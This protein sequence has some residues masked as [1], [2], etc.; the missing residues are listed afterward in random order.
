[1]ITDNNI[2]L[3]RLSIHFTHLTQSLDVEVFQFFKQTHER[4]IDRVVKN[5]D[6][7]F[8]RLE[9]L[10]VF[11]EFRH[12]IFD[13]KRILR[14]V[15]KRTD[16]V[17][18][19]SEIVLHSLRIR[20]TKREV[21]ATRATTRFATSFSNDVNECLTRTFRESQSIQKNVNVLRQFHKN[22][23]SFDVVD[24]D[25]LLRFIKK[26]EILSSI[27]LLHTRDLNSSLSRIAKRNTRIAHIFA[28]VSTTFDLI[29][30]EHCKK[31]HFER[32]AKKKLEIKT[33]KKRKNATT[34]KK[35]QKKIDNAKYTQIVDAIVTK[36]LQTRDFLFDENIK[37][38]RFNAK[39][40]H[41]R[42]INKIKKTIA[43]KVVTQT[44]N[45]EKMNITIIE[46]NALKKNAYENETL[47]LEKYV[48][49]KM[50]DVNDALQN[51]YQTS[52]STTTSTKNASSMNEFKYV[53]SMFEILKIYNAMKFE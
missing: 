32:A 37:K 48:M 36:I 49:K 13:K 39:R 21:A 29:D 47:Q 34:I 7:E 2:L 4:A 22:N 17:L 16:I 12:E 15:F 35:T 30:A 24:F 51:S 1:M 46:T 11:S 28:R 14:N 23:D 20:K 3:F 50:S 25:Q 44:L 6:I 52:S 10:N 8:S 53:K 9:F 18:F 41:T 40:M 43:K 31:L 27:N 38:M 26:A 33:K 19:D 5:D 45:D 42:A